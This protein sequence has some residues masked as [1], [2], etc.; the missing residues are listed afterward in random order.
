MRRNRIRFSRSPARSSRSDRTSNNSS[1]S[2]SGERNVRTGNKRRNAAASD[3]K[4]NGES[5]TRG[6][7]LLRVRCRLTSFLRSASLLNLHSAGCSQFSG[8]ILAYL[9]PLS[10]FARSAHRRST[11]LHVHVRCIAN[12]PLFECIT[13]RRRNQ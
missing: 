3:A 13:R 6:N 1:G 8:C 9:S 11:V 5:K 2:G 10:P 12:A 4:S 7:H